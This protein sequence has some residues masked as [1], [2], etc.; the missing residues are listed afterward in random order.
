MYVWIFW[1]YWFSF[2]F[3]HIWYQCLA[4]T[5]WRAAMVPMLHSAL[6]WLYD[7][8]SSGEEAKDESQND[9]LLMDD[10]SGASG[11]ACDDRLPVTPSCFVWL[12][13]NASIRRML[14]DYIYWILYWYTCY[15]IIDSCLYCMC[16][17][18]ILILFIIVGCL[19]FMFISKL[20]HV[21]QDGDHGTRWENTAVER[22]G[23]TRR[24]DNTVW[25]ED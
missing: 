18:S 23:Y 15:C 13:W 7:S 19:Y 6:L 17:L 20:L 4:S 5:L 10:L 8:V 2:V 16:R 12:S 1:H 3:R 14:R 25:R 21:R 22:D 9:R 24:F 11:N